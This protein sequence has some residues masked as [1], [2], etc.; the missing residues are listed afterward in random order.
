MH[1]HH[2]CA[3]RDFVACRTEKLT[4]EDP[5]TAAKLLLAVSSRIA[6]RL[7]ETTEKLKLYSRLVLAMQQEIEHLMPTPAEMIGRSTKR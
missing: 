1:H 5:A 3:M 6:A 7:R 2:P 4:E